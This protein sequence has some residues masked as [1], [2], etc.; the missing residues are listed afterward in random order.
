MSEPH[1]IK[2]ILPSVMADIR[3]RCEANPDNKDFPSP[4]TS[5]AEGVLAAISDFVQSK[6]RA[7]KRRRQTWPRQKSAV[8]E[9][10]RESV[11]RGGS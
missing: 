3:Q 5:H 2:E 9:N 11:S 10:Q 4:E 8:K 1:H 6:K 7:A